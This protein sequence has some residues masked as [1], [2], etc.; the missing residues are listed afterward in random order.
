VAVHEKI[1]VCLDLSVDSDLVLEGYARDLNREIQDLRKSAR[2]AY[3]DRIV[4]SLSKSD[5]AD[6]VL[7][8]YK[9]WLAEQTLAKEITSDEL[10]DALAS[11]E[12]EIGDARVAIAIAPAS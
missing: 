3:S 10:V 9:A 4:V 6:E 1:V 5:T 11:T 2:L 8:R 7:R 12:L